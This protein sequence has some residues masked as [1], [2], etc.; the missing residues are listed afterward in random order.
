MRAAL[1]RWCVSCVWVLRWRLWMEAVPGP[2]GLAVRVPP[3]RRSV[4]VAVARLGRG[5]GW[6]SLFTTCAIC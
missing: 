4:R 5:A 6:G 2:V 3:C 1:D